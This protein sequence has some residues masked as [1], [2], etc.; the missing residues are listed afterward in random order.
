MMSVID[1]QV[2]KNQN[3]SKR[4]FIAATDCSNGEWFGFYLVDENGTKI[5]NSDLFA[6][7][8]DDG[9]LYRYDGISKEFGFDLDK[10]GR[11]KVLDN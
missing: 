3:I 1:L 9:H 10:Y 5:E 6:I 4:L 11:L 8:K 2:W 7:R